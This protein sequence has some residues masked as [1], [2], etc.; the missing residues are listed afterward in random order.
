MAK[1]RYSIMIDNVNSKRWGLTIQEAYLFSWITTLPIWA[2]K[3]THGNEVYYFAS[4]TIVGEQIPLISN[5]PDTIYRYYKKLAQAGVITYEKILGKDCVQITEKGSHWGTSD[6]S[7][8]NPSSENNPNKLG[9]KSENHS[10]NNPTYKNTN[11]SDKNTNTDKG[12]I[13]LFEDEVL[14]PL[15]FDNE[16]FRAVWKEYL[17]YRRVQHRFRFKSAKYEQTAIMTLHKKSLGDLEAAIDAI[18]HAVASGHMGINPK[19]KRNGSYGQQAS[20]DAANKAKEMIRNS[21]NK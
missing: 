21:M 19:P 18:E 2:E 7:E 6:Y 14:F 5:K 10:E 20:T 1:I 12:A 8:N 9:K 11:T 13:A 15:E 16:R 17:E 3:V 4:R